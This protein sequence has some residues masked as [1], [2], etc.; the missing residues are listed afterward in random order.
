MLDAFGFGNVAPAVTYIMR[1]ISYDI[2]RAQAI[3]TN[4]LIRKSAYSFH[5]VNN[6][7]KLFPRPTSTDDGNKVW[8]EYFVRDDIVD[9][10]RTYT[11]NKVTDPSNIPYTFI[12]YEEINAAGRQWIRKYTLSLAKELL[13]IIR[14]KYASLPLP[15]GEV[16]MDGEAL[17]AEGR[18]EKTALLEELREFLDSVTLAERS[19]AEAD[20]AAANQELLARSPLTIY[21]G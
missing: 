9:T 3:E 10:S 17:K 4:D 20:T 14:S 16:T 5:I 15:N 11:T 2:S 18:E 7:L 1:P 12:T 19:R 13:G 6:V 21:I 8:F